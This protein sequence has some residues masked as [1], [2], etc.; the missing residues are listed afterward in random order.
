MLVV[1]AEVILLLQSA[2]VESLEQVL[3]ELGT[4]LVIKDTL[5]VLL[6]QLTQ[7]KESA[8]TLVLV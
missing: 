5:V 2:A 1:V 8:V 4:L 3:V 6:L 7:F